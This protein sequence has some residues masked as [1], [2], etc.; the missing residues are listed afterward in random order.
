MNADGKF[1][2]SLEELQRW[3]EDLGATV[4]ITLRIRNEP[5]YAARISYPGACVPGKDHYA[6]GFADDIGEAV[7]NAIEVWMDSRYRAA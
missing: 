3:L 6:E 7:A 4:Q 1:F 5:R 2:S